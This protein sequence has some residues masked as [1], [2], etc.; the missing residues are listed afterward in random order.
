MAAGFGMMASRSPFPG[1]AIG[2]GAQ[3]G[4]QTYQTQKQQEQTAKLSQSKIDLEA[5]KLAQSL[6]MQQKHL[7]LATKPYSEMTAAQKD[8]ATSRERAQTA[9][10]QYRQAEVD[11]QNRE[12]AI[13]LRAPVKVGEMRNGTPIMAMPKLNA[14]GTLD[15]YPINPDG[16]IAS[17]PIGTSQENPQPGTATPQQNP[18][19][20]G[21]SASAAGFTDIATDAPPPEMRASAAPASAQ[22]RD[23]AYLAKLAKEDPGYAATIKGIADY[24]TPPN[25]FSLRNNRREKAMADLYQYDPTYDARRFN[26]TNQ[27]IKLFSIGKQGDAIRSFSVAIEHLGTAEELGQALQNGDIQLL[28]RAKNAIKT[29]FG[30]DAPANF[31][32]AKQIVA[33][34]VAKAVIGGQNAEGDR[35][36]LQASLSG[37]SSPAQLAGVIHTFKDLMA[38]QIVGYKRQYENSTGLHNFESATALT[39]RARDEVARID[40]DRS[41]HGSGLPQGG[42]D[43]RA[44]GVPPAEIVDLPAGMT[45][46]EAMKKYPGKTV[47]LPDGRTKVLPNE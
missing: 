24:Q 44:T 17:A 27:A 11:R 5:Q 34:E 21:A 38:G 28:N 42:M 14:Q 1:V 3:Q 4:L 29:Q 2:E 25:M 22:A 39:P 41:S 43:H 32:T 37:A 23:E 20:Q 40:A 35:K 46:A 33:D 47:R 30:Y 45:P 16:S 9:L 31:E 6:D 7:D 18:K 15:Y 36:A 26:S 19:L 13:K 8:A 12:D 10:Q